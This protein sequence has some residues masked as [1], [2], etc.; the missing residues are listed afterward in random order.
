M[1]YTFY[2][3][4]WSEAQPPERNQDVNFIV[5][6]GRVTAMRPMGDDFVEEPEDPEPAIKTQTQPK[7]K[8]GTP[9]ESI[10][11]IESF[12]NKMEFG[13]ADPT[14]EIENKIPFPSPGIDKSE[15]IEESLAADPAVRPAIGKL[16]FT[17]P[18]ARSSRFGLKLYIIG[19]G[20]FA[21]LVILG[22]LASQM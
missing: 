6:D 22:V 17:Q 18:D 2:M 5:Q 4:D 3:S 15:V 16:L 19:A 9:K 12:R 1:R 11:V 10:Q 20:G 8:A 7:Q 14:A 21:L 13:T